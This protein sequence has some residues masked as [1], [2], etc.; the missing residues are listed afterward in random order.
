MRQLDRIV[1][2]ECHVVLEAS[3]TWR[4][5][6]LSV[7]KDFGFAETQVVYLTA[8]WPQR[9][10][11]QFY[12]RVGGGESSD[13]EVSQE[14]DEEEQRGISSSGLRARRRSDGRTRIGRTQE[15]TVSIAR[16]DH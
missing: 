4:P 7:V 16:P 11:P 2:D 12:E 14:G 10:E 8:T 5:R 1:I 3:E 15:T 13:G 9:F 6:I